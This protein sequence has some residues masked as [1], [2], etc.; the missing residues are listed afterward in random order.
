MF[1]LRY[2]EDEEEEEQRQRQQE[3]ALVLMKK[4]S[5]IHH[6]RHVSYSRLCGERED[7]D[8]FK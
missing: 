5:H 4:G 2:E 3:I 8:K 6:K 1:A 7:L